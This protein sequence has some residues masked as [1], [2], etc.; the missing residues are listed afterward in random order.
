[1]HNIITKGSIL[2]TIQ[3][4]LCIEP[5]TLTRCIVIPQPYNHN[6]IAFR[7]CTY[8]IHKIKM[9]MATMMMTTSRTI[10]TATATTTPTDGLIPPEAE[11]GLPFVGVGNCSPVV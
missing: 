3:P 2:R 8:L 11:V 10:T 6:I 1:M 7:R 9:A 4:Y 5:K